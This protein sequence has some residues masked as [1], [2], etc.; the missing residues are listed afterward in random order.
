MIF[1]ISADQYA[2]GVGKNALELWHGGPLLNKTE[3]LLSRVS[4]C[5]YFAAVSRH[6][7]HYG[8]DRLGWATASLL[9]SFL[10]PIDHC[11]PLPPTGFVYIGL[12]SCE[13]ACQG[14]HAEQ[15]CSD[16]PKSWLNHVI[17]LSPRHF[18]SYLCQI[19]PRIEFRWSIFENLLSR[20]WEHILTINYPAKLPFSAGW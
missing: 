15:L 1:P 19:Q 6:P 14:H 20:G 12:V 17:L 7:H 13:M 10:Y 18:L 5:T 9:S 4:W 16:P 3:D 11:W 2:L 8:G